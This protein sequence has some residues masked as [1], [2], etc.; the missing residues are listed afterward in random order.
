MAIIRCGCVNLAGLTQAPKSAPVA[1]GATGPPC[2]AWLV[3]IA[4]GAAGIRTARIAATAPPRSAA[5]LAGD[6]DTV[7]R[8]LRRGQRAQA[9]TAC[10]E[11]R[12]SPF[13]RAVRASFA[14]SSFAAT[15]TWVCAHR[16]ARNVQFRT[17]MSARAGR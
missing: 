11:A 14:W 7:G 3:A 2:I 5:R 1:G 13:P 17:P 8:A 9:L 4:D 6:G 16:T 15:R 12:Q 10:A